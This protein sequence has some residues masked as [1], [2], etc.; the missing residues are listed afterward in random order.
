MELT[1][2]AL[3]DTTRR[4]ML[5]R[6]LEQ[7]GQ[8]LGELVDDLGMTRQSATRHLAVLEASNLVQVIWQGRE[9]R[10][11]LNPV[12]IDEI[13]DRWIDRFSASKTEALLNL[14]QALEQQEHSS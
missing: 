8:T 1:F 11:F 6:L 13:R 2:K 3:A 14:K 10:H 7:P 12:P 4:L 9:K 5:D